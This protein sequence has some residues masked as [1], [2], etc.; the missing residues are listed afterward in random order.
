MLKRISFLLLFAVCFQCLFAV[1]GDYELSIS[2]I[3]L[4]SDSVRYSFNDDT[5][6]VETK[7][8]TILLSKKQISEGKMF[9]QVE[10]SGVWQDPFVASLSIIND[11]SE[12]VDLS[13]SPLQEEFME[14]S[15]DFKDWT[16]FPKEGKLTLKDVPVG[17]LA[18]I[19]LRKTEDI[20]G[21]NPTMVGS[22]SLSYRNIYR[23]FPIFSIE[24]GALLSLREN[25][26][27]SGD[28]MPSKGAIGA[29]MD[30]SLALNNWFAISLGGSYEKHEYVPFSFNEVVGSI[31]ARFMLQNSSSFTPFISVSAS[32]GYF[33]NE[34]DSAFYPSLGISLGTG[35]SMTKNLSLLF[36]ADYSATFTHDSLL[37]PDSLID[38]I[39]HRLGLRVGCA[40]T[41]GNGAAL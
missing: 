21:S 12:S 41:F 14:W 30:L 24:G 11:S 22:A 5:S 26:F 15:R 23:I 2:S 28:T 7:E 17:E 39:N 10:K 34:N 27:H 18:V 31:K 19:Y 6:W 1:S 20:N 35:Y 13:W 37:N 3:S 32:E 4:D 25:R 33:W 16:D 38:S 9:F 8:N 29:W 40:F 36:S